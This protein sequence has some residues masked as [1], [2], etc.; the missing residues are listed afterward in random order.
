MNLHITEDEPQRQRF[1]NEGEHNFSVVAPAGVGKTTAIVKRIANL[2]RMDLYR[3]E[4]LL[5]H[6]VVVTYTRK[7]AAELHQ[8]AEQ[9]LLNGSNPADAMGRLQ[10]AFFGTLHSYALDLLKRYG[11]QMGIPGQLEIMAEKD[12]LKP[13]WI[14]FLQNNQITESVEYSLLRR[15]IPLATLLDLAREMPLSHAIQDDEKHPGIPEVDLNNI[16]EF[17]GKGRGKD[18]ILRGQEQI[19]KWHRAYKSG[20]YSPFP[21]IEKGGD[22]FIARWAEAIAPLQDWLGNVALSWASQMAESFLHYRMHEGIL[23]YDD[24][25]ECVRR[26]L[27]KSDI[28][29]LIRRSRPRFLLDEAQDTDPVQF[30][31]LLELARPARALGRWLEG[32]PEAPEQGRFSMVGDPQQSIYASRADLATYQ[33]IRSLLT[34][35]FAA[36]ELVFSTTWRCQH[37]IVKTANQLLHVVLNGAG[38]V[39]R[40]VDY[41]PLE[42]APHA[43]YGQVIRLP[44]SPSSDLGDKPKADEARE[45]L[46]ADFA[47]WLTSVSIEKLRAR[48]WSDVALL[49]PRNEW[50]GYL[51]R[52]LRRAGFDVQQHSHKSRSEVNPVVAW[53]SALIMIMGRPCD[54][55]EIVGV[56]REIYGL[57]DDAIARFAQSSKGERD[58]KPFQILA[59]CPFEGSVADTLNELHVLREEVISLPLGDAAELVVRKAFLLEKLALLFPQEKESIRQNLGRCIRRAYDAEARRISLRQWSYELQ[60]SAH[61]TPAEEEARGGAIQ[62]L[63][64]HKAKGLDWDAVILPYFFGTT[65]KPNNNYPLIFR[66]D[67]GVDLALDKLH[68]GSERFIQYKEAL[69]E[70]ERQQNERLLYVAMTRARHTLVLVDDEAYFKKCEESL[71]SCLKVENN[72]HN[73]EAFQILPTGLTVDEKLSSADAARQPLTAGGPNWED[74]WLYTARKNISNDRQRVT[75]SELAVEPDPVE[76]AERENTVETE[77]FPGLQ[78]PPNA[79][80]L[81]WHESMEYAPWGETDW[82]GYSDYVISRCPDPERGKREWTAFRQA[83]FFDWFDKPLKVWTEWPFFW[84]SRGREVYEGLIDWLSHDPEAQLYRIVD[85]KTD[86]LADIPVELPKRYGPQIHAYRQALS[87]HTGEKVEAY[88]YSTP[89][90]MLIHV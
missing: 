47:A 22:K 50:L 53:F 46:A 81:W 40:Q 59:A 21:V 30:E 58:S 55:F 37:D 12:D 63:S 52:A 68:G 2:A 16:L 45:L 75:P 76:M 79:Y 9:E 60:D 7:A 54:S 14:E 27:Y 69:A 17:E 31:I 73:L 86:R 25:L 5:P 23:T 78:M 80:G 15:H 36:D 72:G 35:Q 33:K 65:S 43:R 84:P 34:E 18:N 61:K 19:R 38:S 70:R 20:Q 87:A 62:L 41:V 88:L 82:N 8:R 42:A 51:S 64:C 56:L 13:L 83:D 57:S 26:L 3:A 6:L 89:Q 39:Y 32:M 71:A 66:T 28:L 49:C 77:E 10:Q 74:S 67:T 29:Q 24:I 4:P 90:G 85:W 44:L 11:S 48:D 1:Y